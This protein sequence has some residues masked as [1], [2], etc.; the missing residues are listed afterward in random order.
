MT[1]RLDYND[2]AADYARHRKMHPGVFAALMA[3]GELGPGSRVLE[4]GCGSGNY[5]SAIRAATGATVHGID[6]SREMLAA[7]AAQD[8]ELVLAEGSAEHLDFAVGQ[9]D[10]VYSVDVIHH[11]K[12]RPA[13]FEGTRAILRPGGKLCTVTD[14]HHDIARRIP[15]SSHFPETIPIELARYPSIGT[16]TR[17]MMLAGFGAIFEE[18][19]ER[20]Y[21]LTDISG[22]RDRAYSSLHLIDDE[23]FVQGIARLEEDL[24]AG[25]INAVS[26][27]TLLW[28]A[29]RG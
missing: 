5:A 28:G 17:E 21:D 23:S 25:P 10:L 27:Y 11:V 20:T 2:L 16:L 7:A 15:L 6:P 24:A 9:F 18:H 8:P 22:Y 13:F 19:T 4:V 14:S 12:D 3:G 1:A 29:P 26:L